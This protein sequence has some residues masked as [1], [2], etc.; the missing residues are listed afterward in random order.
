MRLTLAIALIA[1]ASVLSA[2]ASTAPSGSRASVNDDKIVY[3]GLGV[4]SAP[5]PANASTT[6]TAVSV[7][8]TAGQLGFQAND[9]A[10]GTP[11]VALRLITTGD[12]AG[13]SGSTEAVTDRLAWVLI[14]HHSKAVYYGGPG[15][16]KTP[17]CDFIIMIDA[18]NDGTIAN[19][20][21]C[22]PP[23]NA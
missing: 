6:V 20:Q 2:C 22:P 7:P 21:V 19:F 15:P 23:P 10:T 16:T 11:S 5:A 14:Y 18:N 17:S 13:A 3:S 8:S 12:F 1:V 9:R 4:E